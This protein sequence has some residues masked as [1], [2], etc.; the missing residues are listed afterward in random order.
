MPAIASRFF[1]LC[2]FRHVNTTLYF[3]KFFELSILHHQHHDC[4]KNNFERVGRATRVLHFQKLS[5]FSKYKHFF[6]NSIAISCGEYY[7]IHLSCNLNT[8][9]SY[10]DHTTFFHIITI[11]RDG[12]TKFTL[13]QPSAGHT[14]ALRTYFFTFAFTCL[15]S[16]ISSYFVIVIRRIYNFEVY[17]LNGNNISLVLRSI[18]L[19]WM[20]VWLT[21]YFVSIE[22][23]LKVM[24]ITFVW[25]NV[26]GNSSVYLYERQPHLKLS[27]TLRM[28]KVFLKFW[29]QVSPDPYFFLKQLDSDR[30]YLHIMKIP[31]ISREKPMNIISWPM[32]TAKWNFIGL[33][34]AL[35]F[36]WIRGIL[37]MTHEF[38]QS[39]FSWPID[40]PWKSPELISWPMNFFISLLSW[41]MNFFKVYFHDPLVSPESHQNEFHAHELQ[42]NSISWANNSFVLGEQN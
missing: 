15:S 11:S 12:Y 34:L 31:W 41:P 33:F 42:S 22:W 18:I 35:N 13:P 8:H 16:V 24:W 9:P 23:Y 25:V 37:F 36:P 4:L 38:L 21:F 2:P 14:F 7:K 32:N 30:T 3:G 27:Y 19:S 17:N 29:V 6:K 20:I 1:P 5:L 26:F 40:L 39:L 28:R 10:N